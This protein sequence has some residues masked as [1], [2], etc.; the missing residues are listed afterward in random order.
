MSRYLK[1]GAAGEVRNRSDLPGRALPTLQ[2][3]SVVSP[4][5]SLNNPNSAGTVFTVT[6]TTRYAACPGD[7]AAAGCVVNALVIPGM[8]QASLNVPL[9]PTGT[10]LTPRLNQVDFSVGKRFVL[11]R[12]RLEPKVDIFNVFN[13]SDY[14][15]VRSLVYSTTSAYKQPGSILQGRI[16]RLGAVVNW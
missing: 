13:S 1:Q 7:S 2:Q 8:T 14:F 10:E 6:P 3:G 12:L 4:N 5:A 15:T 16:V 11:E 9:I